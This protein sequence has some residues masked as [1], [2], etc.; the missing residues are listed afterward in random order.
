MVQS[1]VKILDKEAC[2]DQLIKAGSVSWDRSLVY[3]IFDKAEAD[4]VCNL[5][6]SRWGVEDKMVW[7]PAKNGRFSMKSTYYLGKE[8]VKR[9]EGEASVRNSG[10]DIWKQIWNMKVQDVVRLFLWKAAHEILPTKVNLFK[11][12]I[13]ESK[14]CPICEREDE[15]VIHALWRCPA[16]ADVWAKEGRPV[17]KWNNNVSSFVELWSD[18]QKKLGRDEVE[19]VAYILRRIWLRRNYWIFENKFEEPKKV[20]RAAKQVETEVEEANQRC[21]QEGVHCSKPR[22]ECTKWEKPAREEFK[23]N[24]DA[25]ID[26]KLQI[27]GIGVVVRDDQGEILACLCSVVKNQSATCMVEAMAVTPP[28]PRARTRG[29]RDVRMV[30]TRVTIPS[31]GAKC[32]QRQ[33]MCTKR[34]AA[35]KQVNK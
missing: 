29:N 4:L 15:T 7:G 3:H 16:A 28:N 18:M 1:L 30:T 12:Q 35:D 19:A 6:L 32:L 22:R 33:Q 31:T 5:P 14:V 26:D 9:M 21:L 13:I 20:I 24:W 11:N 25:A 23:V 2:V 17:K 10:V 8:R 34:H 27:V